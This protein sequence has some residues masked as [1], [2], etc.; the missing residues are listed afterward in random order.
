MDDST[1]ATVDPAVMPRD[2]ERDLA[3]QL[4]ERARAEGV[5]LTGPDGLLT[6]LTKRV[7]ET[8]LEVELTDHLGYEPHDP[9]GRGTGNSRNGK[10]TKKVHTDVG[11]VEISIPRDRAGTFEPQVVPKHARRLEGFNE[12]IVSLYGKGMTTGDIQS[13]LKDIYGADVSRDLISKVTD[14]V[15]EELVEWQNRPLDAVYPVVLID[16]I[17][18]KVRDGNVQNRPVYVVMG[19]NLDGERDVLGMWIGPT[20]GE[21]AKHWLAMLTELRNRG[22]VDACIVCCDGL[23]GMPDAIAATWPEAIV[24]TCVVHL[25]RNSLRYASKQHWAQITNDMRAIYTAPTE[26]AAGARF[27]EFAEK[28]GQKYPAM[29]KVWERAW[30]EF[31][32]FLGFPPAIRKVVYTTNAIESLNARFRKA[33]RRRGHFP[34]EQAALKVLYLAIRE[35]DPGRSNA[36]GRVQGWKS[37]LNAFVIHFGDRLIV[38]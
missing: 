32:P 20:G 3:E 19:I 17:I 26:E 36:V 4:V 18:I 5:E 9:A 7:L 31:V 10:T 33:T 27:A 16:C 29:I 1:A 15:V 35:R 28:W 34:N 8:A 25:V 22:V 12:A 11:P 21:G 6:G 13:H 37:A 30:P 14:A 2:V 24:Q 23:R 38:E